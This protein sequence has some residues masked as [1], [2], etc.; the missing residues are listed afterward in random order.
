ML[1]GT[2]LKMEALGQECCSLILNAALHKEFNLRAS[3]HAERAGAAG[4]LGTLRDMDTATRPQEHAKQGLGSTC[5]KGAVRV[6]EVP[7]AQDNGAP[8]GRLCRLQAGVTTS[9]PPPATR[10]AP[11]RPF[12]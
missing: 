10:W 11:R 8:Q 7:T 1:L 4:L 6:A 5:R 9:E 3:G 12:L 2:I